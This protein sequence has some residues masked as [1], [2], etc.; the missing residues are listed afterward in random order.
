MARNLKL[1]LQK[2]PTGD[3]KKTYANTIKIK[4]IINGNLKLA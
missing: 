4:K 3:I 2:I 1:N